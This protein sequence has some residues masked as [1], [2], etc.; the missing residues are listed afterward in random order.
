[1]AKD[2][3]SVAYLAGS[4][5]QTGAPSVC[6]TTDSGA[7]WSNVFQATKNANIATVGRATA[8]MKIGVSVSA[9]R[10]SRSARSMRTGS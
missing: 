4:D 9:L 3:I 2:D 10:G 6:K 1:M 8:E 5:T 7:H